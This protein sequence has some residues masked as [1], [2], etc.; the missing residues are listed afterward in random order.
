MK[1]AHCQHVDPLPQ[2]T[3]TEGRLLTFFYP[4]WAQTWPPE[5]SQ[6]YVCPLIP[7]SHLLTHGWD[8]RF[9]SL[10][11]NTFSA[12]VEDGGDRA[13]VP[14][15]Q[16]SLI[17]VSTPRWEACQTIQIISERISPKLIVDHRRP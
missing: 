10:H 3:W 12:T 15:I 5:C 2:A 1:W 14:S 8:G 11:T 13:V 6:P 4:V 17:S 7:A 9:A 16:L